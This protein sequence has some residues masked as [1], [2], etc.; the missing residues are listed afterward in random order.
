[1][2]RSQRLCR[3]MCGVAMPRRKV[4]LLMGLG[5]NFGLGQI[6]WAKPGAGRSPIYFLT[7]TAGRRPASHQTAKPPQ[8]HYDFRCKASRL[9]TIGDSLNPGRTSGESR[10]VL[11]NI[12]LSFG[13]DRTS[14]DAISITSF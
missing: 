6:L 9:T 5:P 7:L 3:L 10:M 8:S 1:M 12:D 11:K 13:R 2:V 4:S 14:G